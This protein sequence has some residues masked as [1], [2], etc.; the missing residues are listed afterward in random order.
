[1]LFSVTTSGDGAVDVPGNLKGIK[2][3]MVTEAPA[4]GTKVPTTKPV[5]VT[6]ID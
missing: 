4:G 2:A 5:I 1:M 3:A 6:P